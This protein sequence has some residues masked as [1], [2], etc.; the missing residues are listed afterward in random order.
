MS[1][2][3][4]NSVPKI[5]FRN[6]KKSRKRVIFFSF[7]SSL[8]ILSG[9]WSTNIDATVLKELSTFAINIILVIGALGIA[10]FAVPISDKNKNTTK[11]RDEVIISYIGELFVLL[12]VAVLGYI[13]SIFGLKIPWWGILGYC[14]AMI[15][16]VLFLIT[17]TM[18]SVVAYFN[19]RD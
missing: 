18:A 16:M 10:L 12:S 8:T 5:V 17:Q 1:K 15:A 2:P 3:Q 7:L 9:I 14:I 11:N 6:F 19:I 4:Y 13:I